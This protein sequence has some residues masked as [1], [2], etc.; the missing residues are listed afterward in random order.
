VKLPF[1]DHEIVELIV[2]EHDVLEIVQHKHRLLVHHSDFLT[3][4]MRYL[5]LIG[6]VYLIWREVEI[7]DCFV[8]NRYL[9]MMHACLT[10]PSSAEFTPECGLLLQ[11]EESLIYLGIAT[12]A[13]IMLLGELGLSKSIT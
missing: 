2:P 9:I 3:G 6:L 11:K 4:S 12:V 7:L 10:E 8:G 13:Q 5:S 1:H